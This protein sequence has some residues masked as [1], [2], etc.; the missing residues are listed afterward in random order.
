MGEIFATRGCWRP[1][2]VPIGFRRATASETSLPALPSS[3]HGRH[4]EDVQD[5]LGATKTCK[6]PSTRQRVWETPGAPLL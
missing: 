6:A 1:V 4:R 3:V 5:V 2:L